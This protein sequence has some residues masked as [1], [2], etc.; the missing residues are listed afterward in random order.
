MSIATIRL[1]QSDDAA[2]LA[3][4]AECSFRET[5]STAD[6]HADMNLYCAQHFGVEVQRPAIL[7]P[8]H[9]ILLANIEQQLVAFAQVRLHSPQDGVVANQPSELQRLYVLQTWQGRGVA[10]ELMSQILT[11]VNR[12]GAD[13]LWLG[14]WEHNP[15]AI[16]FY[17]KYG[18]QVIG[19]HIF[20]LGRDPQRD[21]IMA[22]AIGT[23]QQATTRR[24]AP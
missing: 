10:Q 17:R 23:T 19:E 9:R 3:H 7:D 20:Q 11:T 4:L 15:R 1:A 12:I 14:V 21:L 2:A 24:T 16:A 22:T 8:N 6:N 5:F 18:F 13:S